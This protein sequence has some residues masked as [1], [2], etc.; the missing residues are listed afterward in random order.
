MKVRKGETGYIRE[1]K[2]RELIKVILEFGIVIALF[3]TGY[4]TTKTRLN[5]LTLVAVL[6]C[7]PASKAMVGYIMLVPRKSLEEETVREIEQAGTHLTKAYDMVLTSYEHVMPIDS[8]VI[9]GNTVCGFT[10][11]EK[12]DLAYVE[13]YIKKTLA[14][15]YFEKVSVKIFRE[16][17]PYLARV[18]AMEGLA[19]SSDAQDEKQEEG[20]KDTILTL[21]M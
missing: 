21:S 11:S 4:I 17:A 16:Y 15:Q 14:N 20:I 18:K 3:V 10:K 13:S 9:T 6:G 12:V 19:V 2:T 8:I 5:L 1:K 7:L